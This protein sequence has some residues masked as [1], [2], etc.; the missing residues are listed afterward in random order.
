VPT[1][2]RLRDALS[3]DRRVVVTHFKKNILRSSKLGTEEKDIKVI[4]ALKKILS[5]LFIHVYMIDNFSL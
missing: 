5:V 1:I 2:C 4:L 3:E